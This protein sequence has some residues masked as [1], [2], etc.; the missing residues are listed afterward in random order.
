MRLV[1]DAPKGKVA[2]AIFVFLVSLWAL[3]WAEV[4]AALISEP[5]A[6]ERYEQATES[7]PQHWTFMCADAGT[8]MTKYSVDSAAELQ[9]LQDFFAGRVSSRKTLDRLGRLLPPDYFRSPEQG[10]RF[11]S[12]LARFFALCDV[13]GTVKRSDYER[14]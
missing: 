11:F 4:A 5:T 8:G 2:I 6:P 1:T 13:P 14:L 3:M 9:V 12:G 10:L 7:W